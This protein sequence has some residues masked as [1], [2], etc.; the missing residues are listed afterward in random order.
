MSAT[1]YKKKEE[2]LCISIFYGKSYWHQILVKA[3]GPFLEEN[4]D[5]LV[6]I[7]S[8]SL[9]RGEHIRLTLVVEQK[10]AEQVARNADEFFRRYLKRHP[11]S[12]FPNSLIPNDGLFV[13]FKNNT[14]HY[15]VFEIFAFE[16]ESQCTGQY[17]VGLSQVVLGIFK[18]YH[19]QTL[20]NYVEIMLQLFTVYHKTMSESNEKTINIFDSLLID[21]YQKIDE[22]ALQRIASLNKDNFNNNKD[23]LIEMISFYDD[24]GDH[25]SPNSWP[26]IWK[27]TLISY[28]KQKMRFKETYNNL[29]ESKRLIRLLCETFSFNDKISVYYLF[30]ETL[31]HTTNL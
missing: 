29:D 18:E 7:L 2:Y 19:K 8:L 30:R 22:A 23:E 3:I 4:K 11:S 14:L 31:L 13:N 27:N 1:V 9:E 12:S 28:K 25:F 17:L 24:S 15:G 21:E 20:N 6:Y 10:N 5:I 26:Y 16:R